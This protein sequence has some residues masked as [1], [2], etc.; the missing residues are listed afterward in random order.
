MIEGEI[1]SVDDVKNDAE[2]LYARGALA[3][4]SGSQADGSKE[5]VQ[6][7]VEDII[8]RYMESQTGLMEMITTLFIRLQKLKEI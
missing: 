4:H 5:P 7:K 6:K 8:K 1:I 2:R 3:P